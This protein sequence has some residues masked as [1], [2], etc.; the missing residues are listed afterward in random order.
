MEPREVLIQAIEDIEEANV[1][2][3]LRQI[4]FSKTHDLRVALAG[5]VSPTAV[6]VN[7]GGQTTAPAGGGGAGTTNGA[8]AGSKLEQLAQRVNVPAEALADV[9]DEQD[10]VLQLIVSG[11]KLAAERA[12]GTKEIALALAGARQ[13]TGEDWTSVDVFRS[14]A[15]HYKRLDSSNF[16]TTIKEMESDAFLFRG[17]PRKREVRLSRPGWDQAAALLKRLAVGSE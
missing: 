15:E 16:A 8:P 14:T 9:F 11:S 7:G 12:R 2:D 3:D 5:V 13:A 4:A 6:P 10:N 17:T 1:P